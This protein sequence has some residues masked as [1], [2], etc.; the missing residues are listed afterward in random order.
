M[1]MKIEPKI[2]VTTSM[3][4]ALVFLTL[5]AGA[6]TSFCTLDEYKAS[7]GLTAANEANALLV[8]WEGGKGQEAQLRFTIVDGTPTIQDISVRRQGGAWT[9]LAGGVTPEYRVTTGRRRLDQEAYPAL[10]IALDGQVTQAVLDHYK[11]DAFW[12][13]PLRIPGDE[14]A[15]GDSTP[16]PAGI[17]G[18]NQLPLPRTE[19][20]VTR[21]TAT[22]KASGCAVKTDGARLE[23]SFPGVEMGIFSGRLQY[24]VYKGTGLLRQEVIAKTGEDDIAYK[25]DAGLKGLAIN[26][27]SKLV[28]RDTAYM[29]Q[30]YQFGSPTNHRPATVRAANRVLA[31]Q[32][33][34]G[35]IAT[36]PPPH[37]FFW[38]REISVNLGYTWYRKDSDTSFS[39]G[40]READSE[41]DPAYAGR[42]PEDRRQNFALYN[43]RPGTEQRM[44]VYFEIDPDPGQATIEAALAYTRNDHY[45]ALPGYWIMARHFHTSP[46]PR[47]LGLGGLDTVLPDY[48]LARAT[49][50]NIFGP[51]G[52]GG[53]QPTGT[54]RIGPRQNLTGP[55]APPV[56][57]P[58]RTMS[59]ADRLKMQSLYYQMARVQSRKDFLVMPN[60]ELFNYPLPAHNDLLISHPTYWVDERKPGEPL[61]EDNPTYGKV[62]HIGS[63]ADL[64]EMA[65]REDMFLMMP[66]PD[67]K[68]SAGY[69][70]AFK[71]QDYFKDARYGGIGFRWGMGVDRSEKRLSDYRCMPLFDEMN[72]W[73]ADLPTSPKYMDAITETYEQGPGDDFYANNPVSYI[74]VE[75]QPGIDNWKPVIDAMMKGNYF[76]TSG[77]VLI[78]SYSVEGT[79]AKRTISADVEWTFP[80]EFAEVVWG[81]GQKTDR[82]IISVTDLPAF[83]KHQFRIPF[84]AAGK[85]WVRFALW[86]SAG[87]GAFVQP[88][89]L[90][91]PTTTATNLTPR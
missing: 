17:P 7:P 30:D 45:Q 68:G 75:G 77:E 27:S 5:P 43:A 2:F 44:P 39:F 88:I 1:Q 74:K 81:D 73:V 55:N 35:S 46:I 51:V 47:L 63:P 53:L 84:D 64:M 9:K 50:I 15:H 19:A 36:F 6:T 4:A 72:N 90:A 18:T 37:N 20:E 14:I 91:G 31:A 60:E 8:T 24:T 33:A 82:Q 62:Y 57:P 76:V 66:H 59:E 41:A 26:Q 38:T 52:A 54:T 89:K 3:V 48:E 49:G 28:W 23:I 71:D 70:A 12:D 40:V 69:P 34:A 85:K 25:Y 79:G 61:V 67:T 80:L 21:A 22:Y 58:G 10:K 13:A 83:G 42:G 56:L 16:P 32:D 87:N 78:P 29:W 86:D 11:W 65:H